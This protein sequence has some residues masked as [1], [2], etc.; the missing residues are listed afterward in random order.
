AQ[1]S[2]VMVLDEPTNDLDLD[3]LEMLEEQLDGYRGTVLLV[4][5]D[6]TFLNNVVTSVLAFEKYS[7]DR[8]GTWLGPDEGWFVNEYVGGYD[9]WAAQRKLPP[10]P[11]EKKTPPPRERPPAPRRM[12][13]KERREL[14]S[15]PG[16]I[17]ALEAEQQQLHA[18]MADPAF[19]RNAPEDIAHARKRCED[20]VPELATDYRRWEELEA[21]AASA[22]G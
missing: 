15:L 14:D 4:S 6:R 17:E 20:I 21:K 16:R 18:H 1:P 19:Y 7:N 8:P 5:H 2:N 10:A 3:T 13:D 22:A 11:A 9:D 12:S